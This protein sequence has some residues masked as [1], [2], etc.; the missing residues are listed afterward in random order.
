[1]AKHECR[2]C[3][4]IFDDNPRRCDECGNT[5]LTPVTEEPE[6]KKFGDDLSKEEIMGEHINEEK[7]I[8]DRIKGLF[9]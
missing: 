1:M 7:S 4:K 8:T 9:K 2:E 3:E 6:V 5:I